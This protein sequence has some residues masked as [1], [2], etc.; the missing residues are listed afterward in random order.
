MAPSLPSSSAVRQLMFNLP[1]MAPSIR[2]QWHHRCHPHWLC[3]NTSSSRL[4]RHH[5]SA[6]NGTI[7]VKITAMS[8]G[9]HK[10]T[11]H[12]TTP[13]TEHLTHL[14]K[15]CP[16]SIAVW[17]AM[18]I[19]LTHLGIDAAI[20]MQE[21]RSSLFAMA[22]GFVLNPPSNPQTT[23]T[24]QPMSWEGQAQALNAPPIQQRPKARDNH[25]L[26][27]RALIHSIA[28]KTIWNCRCECVFHSPGEP[29][30]PSPLKR[31][32]FFLLSYITTERSV[33]HSRRS[34][35]LA[36]WNPLLTAEC[37]PTL[38]AKHLKETTCDNFT[39]ESLTSLG[40]L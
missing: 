25:H 19:T 39:G 37:T 16:Y 12:N 18:E 33:R 7:A 30:P 5:Q 14:L 11:E 10:P 8:P 31:F 6:S 17:Q 23:V 35:P 15:E 34:F 32:L 27:L 20:P 13:P 4:Q 2:L 24:P 9:R 38:S 1:S 22:S 26:P 36:I 28:L 40:C 3:A 21:L 29:L